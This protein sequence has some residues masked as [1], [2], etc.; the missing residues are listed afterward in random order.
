[1][2]EAEKISKSFNKKKVVDSIDITIQRGQ[3]VGLLGPNGAGKSTAFYIIAGLIVPHYGRVLLNGT[4]ITHIPVH[5]RAKLGIGY[6]PQETSLFRGMS[7]YAN[8][9]A[10]VEII[11]QDK[12]RRKS[13]VERLLEE[14]GL[15]HVAYTSVKVLSGGERRKAEIA[16]CLATNPQYI[17]LDEPFA[18]IDPIAVAEI[19]NLIQNLKKKSIGILITDHNVRETLSMIDQGYII[20]NGR[21][22]V[23]GTAKEI[24]EHD[25]A[26]KLYLGEV[27]A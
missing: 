15:L 25:G 21:A 27:F 2:L 24:L 7:V 26:R 13:I 23:S 11:E 3:I 22:L 9:M 5:L 20:Y 14:F 4:D 12:I 19:K 16:R 18:G 6:L 17:L 1:M 8:I 10:A